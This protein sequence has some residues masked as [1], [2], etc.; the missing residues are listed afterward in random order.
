MDQAV[1][2]NFDIE[3]GQRVIDALDQAGYPPEVAMWAMLPQYETW[4][5]VLA[6]SHIHGYEDMVKQLRGAGIV[7]GARPS[8]LLRDI[9][10]PFVKNLR[11]RFVGK[12]LELGHH[13]SSQY[14]GKQYVDEAYI[15]RVR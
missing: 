4:R 14:F 10:G 7:P 15:Y 11:E 3:K 6:S 2:V 8:I 13:I 1:L 5:F 9:G 12:D